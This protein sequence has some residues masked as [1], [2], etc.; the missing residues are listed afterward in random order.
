[1]ARPRTHHDEKKQELIQ[2]SFGLFMKSGYENTS[3][4]DIMSAAQ[5]SKGAMY[6]Y[7]TCKEDILDAVLNYIIDLDAKRL[8]PILNDA[9]LSALEKLMAIMSPSAPQASEELRQATE[10]VIQRPASIFD[11]RAR[12]LSK[13]RSVQGFAKLIR[14]GV[15]SGEFHTEY[16]E[17]MAAFICSSAQAMGELMA[18][19]PDSQN[20]KKMTDAFN[21]LLAQCLGLGEE[22]QALL[23]GFFMNNIPSQTRGAGEPS[24]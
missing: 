21:L 8:E 7:F 16:P 23:K 22:K 20:L 10:Y 13:I 2:I 1:M 3:I 18:F 9:S 5:I 11:Y 4:Q 15:A 24:V 17:E 6:H 14:E 12:E 19:Q